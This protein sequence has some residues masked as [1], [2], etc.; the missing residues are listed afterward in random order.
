VLPIEVPTALRN[1]ELA[2]SSSVGFRLAVLI[3][4]ARPSLSRKPVAMW[5]PCQVAAQNVNRE[6]SRHEDRADP[7]A[8]VTMHTLPVRARLGF[9]AVATISF[10]VVLASGHFSSIAA[11][12]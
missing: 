8:P 2:R 1:V 9:A 11:R 5:N 4:L 7:E 6:H 12:Y 10:M 3:W